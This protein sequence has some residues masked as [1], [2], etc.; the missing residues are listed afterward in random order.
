MLYVPVATSP[1]SALPFLKRESMVFLL[2]KYCLPTRSNCFVSHF[3]QSVGWIPLKLGK[4][5]KERERE[6]SFLQRSTWRI[7]S[8]VCV[9]FFFFLSPSKLKV[10]M[11][12]LKK[13]VRVS[14]IILINERMFSQ[15][16]VT[17]LNEFYRLS[18]E[19]EIDD[20]ICSIISNYFFFLS[21]FDSFFLFFFLD[22]NLRKSSY[23]FYTISMI[24]SW[25]IYYKENSV[26]RKMWF[27]NE[28]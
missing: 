20:T 17:M 9:W 15:M 2:F 1:I 13:N 12:E 24:L 27:I 3:Y 6:S 5:K 25:N 19:E 18:W 14:N 10:E 28:I 23:N 16:L 7:G 11:Q 26:T 4:R 21:I 22:K 8:F